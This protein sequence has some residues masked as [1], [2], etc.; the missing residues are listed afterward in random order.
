LGIKVTPFSVTVIAT[1]QIALV[2]LG[3]V[4]GSPWFLVLAALP[5]FLM[6]EI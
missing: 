1:L 2:I 3:G 5:P 4:T 6:E